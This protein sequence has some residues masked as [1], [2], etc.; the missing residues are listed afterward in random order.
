MLELWVDDAPQPTDSCKERTCRDLLDLIEQNVV[1]L[2]TEKTRTE[3]T[4][5]YKEW[6]TFFDNI[7]GHGYFERYRQIW[8]NPLFKSKSDVDVYDALHFLKLAPDQLLR[9]ALKR[10]Y[11]PVVTTAEEFK[12]QFS[13]LTQ[14]ANKI[15]I[16]DRY[17]LQVQRELMKID[18]N[19]ILHKL[20]FTH[21]LF[22]RHI[23]SLNLIL[24]SLPPEVND[25]AIFSD[26]LDWRTFRNEALQNEIQVDKEGYFNWANGSHKA[27]KNA[28]QTICDHLSSQND[29]KITITFYDCFGPES[30]YTDMEH[31]R[32]IKHSQNR[33]F[34]S[35]AGFNVLRGSLGEVP[36]NDLE[37]SPKTFMIQVPNTT[38]PQPNL[39]I[40][41]KTKI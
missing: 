5:K 37:I 25:I 18:G 30:Q 26:M 11:N 19:S 33:T 2:C 22:K 28:M 27:K 12:L 13:M 24:L 32:Y 7:L 40:I 39:R 10:R 41:L 23:Q 6:R 31:D 21:S 9:T 14:G 35:S 1:I 3:W 15:E 29:K 16:Y 4:E 8:L 36:L 17:L 34:I 38:S 20:E